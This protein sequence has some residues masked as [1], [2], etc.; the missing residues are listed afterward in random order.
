MRVSWTA[1]NGDSRVVFV[2]EGSSVDTFPTD[3]QSYNANP[4]FGGGTKLRESYTVFSGTGNT[5]DVTGLKKGTRYYF[6]V[7]E[8]NNNSG[9]YEYLT[10]TGVATADVKTGGITA[11]FDINDRYQCLE[12]NNSIFTNKSSNTIGGGMTYNW[13]FGDGSST[14][15]TTSPSHSFTKGGI[16]KVKLT[17][18]TTGCKT[19]TVIT[20]TVVVPY[21]VNFF[22]DTM[23]SFDTVQC[24]GANQFNLVNRS[25]VPNPPIYGAWDRS[26]SSW[27]TSQGHMGTAFNFDFQTSTPGK[28]TVKLVMARQVQKGAEFCLDSIERVVEVRPP[29]LDTSDISFSDSVLC[30]ATNEYTFTLGNTS[31]IVSTT[32]RVGD[33]NS[34]TDNPAIHSYTAQGRYEVE[35]EVEDINGCKGIY[36]DSVEVVATPNNFFSG[37]SGTYCLGDP[38]V[39]LKPNL[40]GG[41]FKGGNVDATDSTFNP[42]VVGSY[43]V[44][45]IYTIGNCKDT[46]SV[47]TNVLDRP[48]FNIGND[49]IICVNTNITLRADDDNL[50]YSWD[51]QSTDQTRVVSQPGIYWVDGEDGQCKFRDSIEV[52]QVTLP[53]LELGNDT[54]I[55]GGEALFFDI[56]SD[57]GSIT[58]SD[59]SPEGFTRT[60]S[61]SGFYKA[62]INHPCGVVVDSI[63]VDILPTA[64]DIFIPNAFSPN[65]DRLNETFYPQGLFQFTSM[66]IFNE[67]GMQLFESYEEGVGWDGKVA[68]EVCPPGTYYFLIRYQL[69]VNG[70]YTKMVAKG[71]VY[72][73]W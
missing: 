10:G 20:D 45:Y 39:N 27:T 41:E 28:I 8:F 6:A 72:L 18:T 46:F 31:D 30:L 25:K 71:P 36:A 58:W 17:A 38:I 53:T 13:N 14:V 65:D 2:R 68:G 56:Q 57:A 54:S 32:W 21:N 33:G 26:R 67:Y 16:F 24:F 23:I 29:P 7:F 42:N 48:S 59:G 44:E 50:N 4:Q 49:T 61:E 37:L 1:G 22:V 9:Q 55:C 43:T 73:M 34:S 5:V 69:P 40:P 66:M 52:R 11:D 19:D 63:M 64:C 60:L 35:L 12:G 47:T 3:F 70:T 51:D 15:A 62:V